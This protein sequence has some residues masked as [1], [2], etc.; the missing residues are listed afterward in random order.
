MIPWNDRMMIS[1]GNSNFLESSYIEEILPAHGSR[2]AR[3]KRL[4]AEVGMLIRATERKKVRSM[5]KLKSKH[6]VLSSLE[7]ETI[8][9]KLNRLDFCPACPNSC[10]AVHPLEKN[11]QEDHSEVGAVRDRTWGPDH[12]SFPR[13]CYDEPDGRCGIE[14]RRFSYTWHIPERRSGGDRRKSE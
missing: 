8:R 14:R 2:A 11:M 4:A 5:I 9:S 12:R 6:I 3:V 1:I 10:R 13:A 7:P